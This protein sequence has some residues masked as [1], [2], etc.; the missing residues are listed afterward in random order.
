[1][2]IYKFIVNNICIVLLRATD[3]ESCKYNVYSVHTI[4]KQAGNINYFKNKSVTLH[5]A[6]RFKYL[7]QAFPHPVHNKK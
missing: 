1:M 3:R 5:L 6:N 7:F 2:Y 4:I